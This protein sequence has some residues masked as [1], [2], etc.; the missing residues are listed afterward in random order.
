[1]GG[2]RDI[3]YPQVGLSVI[4]KIEMDEFPPGFLKLSL[5][6]MEDRLEAPIGIKT[7]AVQIPNDHQKKVEDQRLMGEFLKIPP[8]Q[9]SVIDDGIA[10]GPAHGSLLWEWRGRGDLVLYINPQNPL[11][12]DIGAASTAAHQPDLV[13]YITPEKSRYHETY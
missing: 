13:L 10:L 4:D 8:M 12:G 6:K 2:L 3:L 9:E 7:P 5:R 11:T 1:M